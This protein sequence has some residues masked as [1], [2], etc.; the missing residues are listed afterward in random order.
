MIRIRSLSEFSY[1]KPLN[2]DVPKLARQN[3]LAHALLYTKTLKKT[4]NSR[5]AG[6][7]VEEF[8][9][10]MNVLLKWAT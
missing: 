6:V 1:G 9:P 10:N 2:P 5:F 7:F 8:L 3:S 4:W